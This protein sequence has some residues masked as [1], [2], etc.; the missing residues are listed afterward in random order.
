MDDD[1]CRREGHDLLAR[2]GRHGWVKEERR[3]E[4]IWEVCV[5]SW[6]M[7]RERGRV[8][9][10]RTEGCC[11]RDRCSCRVPTRKRETQRPHHRQ[12]SS[13]D[14][15]GVKRQRRVQQNVTQAMTPK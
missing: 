1:G 10:R 15:T 14:Q 6:W 11:M 9:I 4:L 2:R 7:S 8:C 5:V 3:E 12:A 13:P